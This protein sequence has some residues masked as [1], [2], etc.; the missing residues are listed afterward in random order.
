MSPLFPLLVALMAAAALACLLW[1]LL[2]H[3]ASGRAP[4]G[5]AALLSFGL[6]VAALALYLAVG[7]P[8]ALD[9]VNR[10]AHAA[11]MS[12]V[13]AAIGKLEQHLREQPDD[14]KGWTLLARAYQAMQRPADAARAFDRALALAPE[15][16]DLM[17]ASAEAHSLQS[18]DHR[19]D[20][21]TRALLEKAVA[22]DPGQQRGLWL[23]GIADYQRGHYAAAAS[24]WQRLLPLLD[25][26]SEVAQA[27]REQIARAQAGG[28]APAPASSTAASTAA[29][30][31]N[32][33]EVHVSLS[34]GLED[35]ASKDASVFVYARAVGGP[36]A[37]LAVAR[38][39]VSDLPAEVTLSDQMAMTP[40]LKL[41]MFPR[42]EV[43]ARVS[44]NGQALPQPGDLE[45]SPLDITAAA[46]PAEAT[47]Q[48]DHVRG[49]RE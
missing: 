48:I 33:L 14:L 23:L 29:T 22:T 37:P 44:Q 47:L 34:P 25:P 20:D 43:L 17:V 26:R 36:P 31:L 8:S 24:T 39:K 35:K 30:G 7:T 42:I 11:S 19:I 49:Q 9:P 2:R 4:V 13:T 16:A 45:S 3:R 41:S 10:V 46:P 6:P 40:Q 15:N 38:I 12:D 32:Q 5:L 1:P 28:P 18:A 27:V 21:A